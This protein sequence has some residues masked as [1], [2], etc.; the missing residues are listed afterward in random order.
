MAD[1]LIAT[2]ASV[3]S[4]LRKPIAATG[5]VVKTSADERVT[6]SPTITSGS[7]APAAAQP[8][9]SL[10][11]RTGALPG[12]PSLY[13]RRSDNKWASAESFDQVNWEIVDDMFGKADTEAEHAWILNSGA[14]AQAIDPALDNTQAGGV[15]QL[16]TGDADG[17]TAN[18]GSQM[19]WGDLPIQ[20]D[21]AGGDVFIEARI[22]I[23]TAVTTVSVFFGLT[24]STGLEE[25]FTNSSDTITSTA[26]DGGGFLFDTDATTDEWW[27]VAVDTDTDDTGNAALGSGP[28]ADTWQI[29][30][31]EVSNDG[32]TVRYYID[33][34]LVLTLSGAA[35]IGPDVVLYPTI[36]ACATT[37]TSRTVDVDYVRAG[38]V[39]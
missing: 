32:A 8:E 25:P 37:T 35:G 3:Y 5:F 26:T 14:D 22:R 36:I 16:V 30:R 2:L 6:A 38:G 27:G 18:D 29:L 17:T 13:V 21:S 7:G 28:T 23:K 34:A 24:D 10:Y 20:L 11:M 1:S 39:R 31:M 15:W 19:V 9:G 4:N 33:G 12:S